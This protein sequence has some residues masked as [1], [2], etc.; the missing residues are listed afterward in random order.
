M[1]LQIRATTNRLPTRSLTNRG[2]RFF[3][4]VVVAVFCAALAAH[5][6]VGL[7]APLWLDEAGTG[8]FASLPLLSDL[9]SAIRDDS[10]APAYYVL[11]WIWAKLFGTSN[12]ALHVLGV[13]LTLVRPLA[14]FFGLRTSRPS[15]ALV[16]AAAIA[17][18]GPGIVQSGYARCYP[19]LLLAVVLSCVSFVRLLES[20]TRGRA[21][22]WAASGT[23]VILTHYHGI[24]LVGLQ[25]SAWVAFRPHKAMRHWPAAFAFVPV[26]IWMAWHAPRLIAYGAPDVAWYGLLSFGDV[27]QAAATLLGVPPSWLPTALFALLTVEFVTHRSQSARVVTRDAPVE[28]A[29]AVALA[30]AVLLVSV[31]VFRPLFTARYLVAFAPGVL[32]LISS[33]LVAASR[34]R[35]D[36]LAALL[37]VYGVLASL[38]WF[39]AP[40][41]RERRFNFESA[42]AW[43]AEAR[44]NRLVYF[45]DNPTTL[46]MSDSLLNLIGGFFLRRDGLAI[47]VQPVVLRPNADM[48]DDLLAKVDGHTALLWLSDSNVQSTSVRLYPPRLAEARSDLDC[49][50]FGRGAIGIYACR[51][52]ILP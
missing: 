20:P 43:I 44:P 21:L 28:I 19:L 10:N 31:S 29:G 17:F 6:R 27:W 15:L 46:A 18:W 33:R 37:S 14:A 9:L 25:A 42:S 36:T 13:V 24:W 52:R 32:L 12:I 34:G 26:L 48:N 8:A 5:V 3:A 22:A 45:W 30:A 2:R 50:S 11:I 23:L 49:R 38:F 51:P 35:V 39:G 16:W 1:S 4:A 40:L 41:F 47:D 7:T